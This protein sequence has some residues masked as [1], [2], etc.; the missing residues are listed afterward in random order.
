MMTLEQIKAAVEAEQ[1]VCW[2]GMGYHVVKHVNGDYMVRSKSTGS[3]FPL[4]R[5][6]GEMDYKPID[7]SIFTP[8]KYESTTQKGLFFWADE[9][10]RHG[11]WMVVSQ[12]EGFEPTEAFDDWF[13]R[14]SDADEVAQKLAK[15]EAV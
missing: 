15:G 6:N 11:A 4:V 10:V 13:S 12:A 8:K 3:M 5:K 9:V 14:L 1:H 2:G 7:F